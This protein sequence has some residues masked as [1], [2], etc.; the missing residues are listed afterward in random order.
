MRV[1]RFRFKNFDKVLRLAMKL[2]KD[3]CRCPECRRRSRIVRQTS[4]LR[5]HEIDP[6]LGGQCKYLQHFTQAQLRVDQALFN[7]CR[8]HLAVGHRVGN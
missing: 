6:I 4:K 2:Y 3:G 5:R 1:T 8:V 7:K